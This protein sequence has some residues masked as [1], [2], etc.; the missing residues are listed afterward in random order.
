MKLYQP[1]YKTSSMS[2]ILKTELAADL[3]EL[4][5]TNGDTLLVHSDAS[6]IQEITGYKWSKALPLLKEALLV[7]IGTDGTLVA[8]T[9][10]WDFCN[11]KAYRHGKT[12]SQVGM[13]SQHI[14]SDP[15][16]VRSMHPIYSFAAIGPDAE[17]LMSDVSHSSFGDDSVFQRLHK[18]NAKMLFFNVSFQV[19]TFVHYVEQAKTVDYRFLKQFTGEVQVD[20]HIYTDTFDFYVRYLDREVINDFSRINDTLIINKKMQALNFKGRCPMMLTNCNDVYDT[21]N[22]QLDKDPYCLLKHPPTPVS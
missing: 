14:L 21:I 6:A 5:V 13:F 10:N 17:S 11:G 15:R 3:Q 4:G 12:R 20:E 9:F 1:E 19:C 22:Q 2:D 18:R 8:P 16:S 7:A